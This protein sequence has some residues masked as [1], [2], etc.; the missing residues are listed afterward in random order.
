[1]LPRRARQ[2]AAVGMYSA[3]GG[4]LARAPMATSPSK[5][6]PVAEPRGRYIVG[7]RRPPMLMGGGSLALSCGEC[8]VQLLTGVVENTLRGIVFRCP[9]CD[10][11]SRIP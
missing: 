7:V 9:G 10:S 3:A 11:Y 4:L 5:T 8:G 6:V 1:M 2:P